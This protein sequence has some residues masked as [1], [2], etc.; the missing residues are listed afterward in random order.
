MESSKGG[1]IIKEN[2]LF[3]NSASTSDQ[4]KKE[5]HADVM[6]IMM[7]DVIAK[8]AMV[9]MDRKIDLLM[10]AVEERE[11]EITTLRE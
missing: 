6:F 4:S 11:H 7:A 9:K 5:S 10:K 8:A 2:P 1:T 3:D